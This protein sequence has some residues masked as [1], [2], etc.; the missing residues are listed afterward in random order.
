MRRSSPGPRAGN[1]SQDPKNIVKIFRRFDENG[2]GVIDKHEFQSVLKRIDSAV[3]N[4][5]AVDRLFRVIDI[6][7]AG[8]LDYESFV[9]W[10][11]GNDRIVTKD[12]QAFR[13]AV[14]K[15]LA[16]K[17][18]QPKRP[19]FGSRPGSKERG[20]ET[21]PIDSA[22]TNATTLAPRPAS[23]AERS[24]PAAG[25]AGDSVRGSEPLQK[26]AVEEQDGFV[27][28]RRSRPEA[29]LP[30]QGVLPLKTGERYIVPEA[31]I[32]GIMKVP[33]AFSERHI[34]SKAES[35]VEGAASKNDAHEGGIE[36]TGDAA[37]HAASNC[38]DDAN[39][40]RILRGCGE[41]LREMVSDAL[42]DRACAIKL[43]DMTTNITCTPSDDGEW[44][45]AKCRISKPWE[46]QLHFEST[47]DRN[48]DGFESVRR[49]VESHISSTLGCRAELSTIEPDANG[50]VKGNLVLHPRG[51]ESGCKLAEE[52]QEQ[53][54]DPSSALRKCAALDGQSCAPMLEED[55]STET[56]D[57]GAQG[58]IDEERLRNIFSSPEFKKAL[59]VALH[60]AGLPELAE[61]EI[62]VPK[63]G[64]HGG[65]GKGGVVAEV[66]VKVP[67]GKFG[68]KQRER[69]E[70]ALMNAIKAAGKSRWLPENWRGSAAVTN[71]D[72]ADVQKEQGLRFYVEVPAAK[73]STQ[74]SAQEAASKVAA[75]A[76][77]LCSFVNAQ[78]SVLQ[79]VNLELCWGYPEQGKDFLDGAALAF[80]DETLVQTVD[81]QSGA[82]EFG[83][84]RAPSL[85]DD[86]AGVVFRSL[87]C[88][89][90]IHEDDD[91][92]G[93]PTEVKA[94]WAAVRKSVRHSGD[95]M[96]DK[97]KLGKH[98]MNVDLSLLPAGVNHMYF[99]LSAFNCDDISAFRIAAIPALR[100]AFFARFVPQL[101]LKL[102]SLL[103]LR[104]PQRRMQPLGVA[105][106]LLSA[107][108]L[109]AGSVGAGKLRSTGSAVAHGSGSGSGAGKLETSFVRAVAFKHRLRVCN[110]YPY[111][112][113]LDVYKGPMKLT[114][115]KPLAYK[116][117]TDFGA[118]LQTGDKLDFK[119]GD[120]SAGTF[121]VSDLPESDAVLLLVIH[122]HDVV[123]TAV[124]F[125][126]HIFANLLNA[127]V[128]VIDTYKGSAKS[129]A[130]ITD[131]AGAVDAHHARRSE[132]LRYNSVVALNPGSYEVLLQDGSKNVSSQLVAKN[133]ESYV[134]L[135]V[136]VEAKE[137][138]SYPEELVVYPRYESSLHGGAASAFVGPTVLL[139]A[140]L[141]A[142]LP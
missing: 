104:Q 86:G 63:N 52:L 128:A 84:W 56:D 116:A 112:V 27:A 10:A 55:P 140:L 34:A 49:D 31:V 15:V 83:P 89:P 32:S 43:G 87:N 39:K 111:N 37:H 12:L 16:K 9:L 30:Q 29:E 1:G 115:D 95:L 117:C 137:G 125:E 26:S 76:N 2:D 14:P 18:P 133:R 8:Q 141:A 4:E 38:A 136:G 94:A 85:Y 68:P 42:P 121:A 58:G 74:T 17:V 28:M 108:L 93:A 126:S 124:A 72:R 19:T 67:P 120:A 69:F 46:G 88:D 23:A 122:R 131:A 107:C 106:L 81:Y 105:R 66:G 92:S 13:S 59:P 73:D 75:S 11:F 110:A 21:Q 20:T 3:W 109:L 50:K 91:I 100:L 44:V 103:F 82:K 35:G 48:E 113:A 71:T 78:V 129:E 138:P 65:D 40:T 135:R 102:L 60:D 70:Q 54:E 25:D 134:V 45:R 24:S 80:A 33:E 53:L 79:N 57:F 130:R 98:I 22:A 142:A 101:P 139:L 127:Q 123:T 119:M 51:S 61:A 6:Q 62:V 7:G 118:E 96:N 47:P 132:E 99:L 97:F 90:E 36:G 64:F 114:I 41:Q 5:A 77:S